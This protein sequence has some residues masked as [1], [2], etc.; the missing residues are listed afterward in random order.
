MF[1]FKYL[2]GFLW[3][4]PISLLGWIFMGLLWIFRQVETVAVY[5]NLSFV[6]DLKAG[7]F[8]C[9]KFM[10]RWYGFTVG[11][12]VVV[13][14]LE[15]TEKTLR[16]FFH[17]TRHVM[18]QYVCGVF[19]LLLYIIESVRIWVFLKDEHSY[20]DNWFEMDARRYA[21]QP[22]KIGREYWPDGKTDRWIWW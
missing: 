12:N 18:Q 8:F 22:I 13:V 20:L 7:G 1:K 5:P 14:S 4:L 19:F 2:L 15:D 16:S 3:V 11:N 10:K 21:G 9:R 6:W 17:E